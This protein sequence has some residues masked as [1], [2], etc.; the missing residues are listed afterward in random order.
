MENTVDRVI[1]IHPN[2]KRNA[3]TFVWFGCILLFI[4]W[5]VSL[6]LWQTFK[7]QLVLLICASLVIVFAGVLK[8][9]EPRTSFFITPEMIVYCH[10]NGQ[11]KLQWQDIIRIGE[12]KADVKGEHIQLPYVGIKLNNL[13]HIAKNI[14]PRL[15]NKLIHE[16][17]ELLILA[18]NNKAINFE[19]SLINF[20]PYT[21][22]EVIYKGPIAAWLHR[23]EQLVKVY[24]YHLYL[25]ESSLDRSLNKFLSLLKECHHYTIINGPY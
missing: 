25:P 20:E 10:R 16:Q 12:L 13:D 22:N 3:K 14:S 7:I 17:Q 21:L 6:F 2:S 23:S 8:Y 15:A 24:G 5:L 19:D 18:I 1:S 4:F 9:L 11:W